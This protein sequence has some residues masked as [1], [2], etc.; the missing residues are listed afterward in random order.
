V[1]GLANGAGHNKYDLHYSIGE[2]RPD[3]VQVLRWGRDDLGYLA[4]PTYVPF[5]EMWLRRD[6]AHLRWD[7][8]PPASRAEP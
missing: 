8:L 1:N 3:V 4:G 7:R 6:S 2:R 5:G